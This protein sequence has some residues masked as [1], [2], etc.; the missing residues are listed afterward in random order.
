MSKNW[1]RQ[2]AFCGTIVAMTLL[3]S[4]V[5]ITTIIGKINGWLEDF[6]SYC[7]VIGDRCEAYRNDMSYK[8]ELHLDGRDIK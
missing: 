2:T 4:L 8:K 7:G 6:A 5:A 3:F 1:F